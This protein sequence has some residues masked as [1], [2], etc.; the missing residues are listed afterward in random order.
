MEVPLKENQKI[1]EI[2]SVPVVIIGNGPSGI[3][4][5]YLLS[6][7]RPYVKADAVHP[8]L[9][10]QSKLQ[11]TLELSILDQDLDYLSEGLEGRSHSPVALLLDTLLRPDSDF[12]GGF[13]SVLRWELR[14][15]LAIPHLVLGE[16]PPG[17]A[18]HSF[19]GSMVTLSLG[20]WMELPDLHLR[21]WMREK[22]R[23]L[24]NDRATTADTAEYY[25]HYVKAKG[26]Q[27]NFL[28]GTVVTSVRKISSDKN[29]EEGSTSLPV[30]KKP[31]SDF[32]NAEERSPV[33]NV[34]IF[35]VKGFHKTNSGVEKDFRIHTQKVVLA[36]G[37]YDNPVKLGAEGEGL[38]FVFHRISDLENVLKQ[39]SIHQKSDPVLIVGGGLTAA[40]AILCAYH[41][42]IPVIH[43][44]RRGVHDPGLIFNQLPKMMY[45]EY[46]KVHQ[47]MIEQ[48]CSSSEAY[49]GYLSLPQHQVL[50]FTKDK[51]CVLEDNAGKRKIYNISMA[52]I[53]IGSNP[54]LSFLTNDGRYLAVDQKYSVN[55]KHNP[56]DVDPY[57]HECAH[58]AGLYAVGPL[59]GDHFVR[60]L[61][62]GVLAVASSLLKAADKNVNKY[63][64]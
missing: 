62:G 59:A 20:D 36:T 24:R 18:W 30:S 34:S 29:S 12:G 25:Q 64:I 16:G 38:P 1:A 43:A 9:I 17:G 42:N 13:E 41:S 22:R 32:C 58:E 57:T 21:D 3:C 8:N 35:E 54:N 6:G 45:P 52:L 27:R 46:H 47:M 19:K 44:F 63:Q 11:E 37:T 48:S 15:D 2:H 33:N 50:Q 56:I 60:F 53:L 23:N 51:K 7:Y 49:E 39:C 26:L 40:D 55:S 4:L 10:L 28:C 31:S 61:Q 14:P 5:S